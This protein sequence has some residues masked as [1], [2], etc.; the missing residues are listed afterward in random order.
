MARTAGPNLRQGSARG[1]PM[2][3]A[4][5]AWWFAHCP[6]TEFGANGGVLA[7]Q[8]AMTAE[9]TLSLVA[10]SLVLVAGAAIAVS[11]RQ[12]RRIE[13]LMARL[14]AVESRLAPGDGDDEPSPAVEPSHADDTSRYS[15]DA[16]A[17]H[18]SHVARLLS[19]TA[20][21]ADVADQAVMVI[22]RRIE[23]PIQA[24]DLADE[25][26]ISVRTLERRISES[27]GCTPSRLILTVK[28]R[29]A[30]RLIQAGDLLI[31]QVAHRLAFADS[32]HLSRRY[33]SFYRCS[34]SRH[35]G[36]AADRRRQ[37]PVGREPPGDR[38]SPGPATV[39]E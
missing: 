25:L 19:R 38:G 7:C 13:T 5:P 8:R 11:I 31:G 21:P 39:A 30:R 4:G 18:S 37:P 27:F 29:E 10:S 26:S 35:H 23:D 15:A 20:M 2:A 22:Y 34:P 28:M 33:R 17:G 32:A 9:L 36:A 24:S 3:G 14:E 16:L 1:H 12:R 6:F